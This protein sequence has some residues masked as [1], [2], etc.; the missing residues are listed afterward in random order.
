MIVDTESHIQAQVPRNLRRRAEQCGLRWL[1]AS[2]HE[3]DPSLQQRRFRQPEFTRE[4]AE[5]LL[6]VRSD[7]SREVGASIRHEAHLNQK[8]AARLSC[9]PP[10]FAQMR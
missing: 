3:R 9:K 6:R 2:K 7:P 4:C 1:R 5:T 10:C 8:A